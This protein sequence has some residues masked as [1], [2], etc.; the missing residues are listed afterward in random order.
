MAG[1]VV[2]VVATT[3]PAIGWVIPLSIGG[4]G[5]VAALMFAFRMR[6]GPEVTV[7]DSFASEAPIGVMNLARVRVAG[8]GGFGLVVA[9]GIVALQYALTTA[10]VLAGLGGGLIGALGVI[11][12]RRRDS[13][14]GRTRWL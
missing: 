8:L 5:V 11:A 3:D 12:Y 10:A 6:S 4:G 13:R 2:M 14:A 1:V 9:S 7:P